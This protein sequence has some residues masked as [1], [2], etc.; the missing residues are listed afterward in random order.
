MSEAA[1]KLKPVLAALS[2]EDREELSRYLAE[3]REEQS[4][5]PAPDDWDDAWIEEINRRTERLRTGEVQGI[6]ADEV[7]RQLR[8]KYG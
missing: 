6:P 3:L 5:E 8:E 2:A 4:G 1:E 7:M